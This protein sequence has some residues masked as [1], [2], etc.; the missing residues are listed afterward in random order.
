MY[1]TYMIDLEK[2][3]N[4]PRRKPLLVS[5]ARQVGKSYLIKDLFAEKYFKDKYIYMLLS[6]YSAD[7]MCNRAYRKN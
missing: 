7:N 2:W 5:G 4:N 6:I 3:L 1:R